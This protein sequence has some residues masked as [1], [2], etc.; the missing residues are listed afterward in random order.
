[1]ETMPEMEKI[2]YLEAMVIDL[3]KKEIWRGGNC[4][5]SGWIWILEGLK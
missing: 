5:E 1:M 3:F 2:P 4:F